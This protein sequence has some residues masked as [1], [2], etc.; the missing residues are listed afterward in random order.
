MKHIRLFEYHYQEEIMFDKGM[1]PIHDKPTHVHIIDALEELSRKS[2]SRLTSMKSITDYTND[3]TLIKD[4]VEILRNHDEYQVDMSDIIDFV[5][6]FY[7][8]PEKQPK[9]WNN[10]LVKELLNDEDR[11]ENIA[12]IISERISYNP[13]ILTKIG[14]KAYNDFLIDKVTD[15]IETFVDNVEVENN[16]IKIYRAIKFTKKK[17]KDTYEII[18]DEFGRLGNYWSWEQGTEEP[19]WADGKGEVYTIHALARPEDVNW[20]STIAK[21]AYG[22]NYEKEVELKNNVWVKVYAIQPWSNNL[23]QDEKII[24]LE[25]PLIVKS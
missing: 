9:Y 13:D 1:D 20:L 25:E 18:V 4:A 19:Y 8:G 22:L 21:N 3:E 2:P 15:K 24:K 17:K 16:L 7:I 14:D 10:K 23:K 11:P 5:F 6:E 12:E